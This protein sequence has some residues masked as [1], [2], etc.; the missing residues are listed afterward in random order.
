MT[1]EYEIQ[2]GDT[3]AFTAAFAKSMNDRKVRKS[4]GAYRGTVQQVL[5]GAAFVQWKGEKAGMWVRLELLALVVRPGG[6]GRAA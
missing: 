4:V 1:N 2:A 6:F 5:R 3:V